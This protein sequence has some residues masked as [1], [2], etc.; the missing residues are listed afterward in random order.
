MDADTIYQ[1]SESTPALMEK[2]QKIAVALIQM[3]IQKIMA[4]QTE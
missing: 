3:I 2:I 1:L 4:M